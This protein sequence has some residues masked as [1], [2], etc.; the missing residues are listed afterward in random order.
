MFTAKV[1]INLK[2]I[3][4]I[5][6]NEDDQTTSN[7]TELMMFCSNKLL[8]FKKHL[9]RPRIGNN[10]NNNKIFENRLWVLVFSCRFMCLRLWD[11]LKLRFDVLVRIFNDDAHACLIMLLLYVYE[12]AAWVL[13]TVATHTNHSINAIREKRFDHQQFSW[14]KWFA[15]E[16]SHNYFSFW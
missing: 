12:Y 10:N 13:N 4:Q 15:I 8:P 16:Q 9:K 14:F 6:K 2:Q 3:W 1:R 11:G 5:L 7:G